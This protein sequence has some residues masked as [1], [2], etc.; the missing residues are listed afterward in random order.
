MFNFFPFKGGAFFSFGTINKV[1]GMVQS[2]FENTDINKITNLYGE[3]FSDYFENTDDDKER[4][5]IDFI[6]FQSYDDMYLLI[7]EL[8]G[9]NLKELSIR[10]DPGIIEIN[11]NR[12]EMSINVL[13]IKTQ[14]KKH[15]NKKF[16][17]IEEIDTNNIL[18]SIDKEILTIRMPKKYSFNNSP[19]IVDI[20]YTEICSSD[21]AIECVKEH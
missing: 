9:I 10:Y 20:D 2:F 5:E 1:D 3:A 8:K 16:E 18:K 19:E 14:V 11:L 13:G 7:I 17:S 6:D 4:A 12:S 21:K 15:Y